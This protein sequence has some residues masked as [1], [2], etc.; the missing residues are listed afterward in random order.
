MHLVYSWPEVL[1]VPPESDL[2]PA[3]ELV[4]AQQQRGWAAGEGGGVSYAVCGRVGVPHVL[5]LVSMDG[6]PS[7]T[8]TRSARY[9]AIMK[10]CSTTNA[11]FF[12]CRINLKGQRSHLTVVTGSNR[13][14]RPFDDL[15]SYQTLFR[16]QVGRRLINQVNVGRLEDRERESVSE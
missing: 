7:K 16:V 6:V 2:Q 13:S 1:A 4:H 15:C 10:S 14:R 12:A 9:V 3:Q 5:A 11:V 8:T